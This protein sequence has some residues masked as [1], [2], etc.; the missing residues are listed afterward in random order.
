VLL[1][2]VDESGNTGEI[3]EGGSLTYSLGCALIYSEDRRCAAACGGNRSLPRSRAASHSSVSFTYDRH[4]HVF[5]EVDVG[6]A[7]KLE[8]LRNF[9]LQIRARRSID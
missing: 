4:G 9:G 6:A 8:A 2:Y 5:P 7:A 3:G 1:A